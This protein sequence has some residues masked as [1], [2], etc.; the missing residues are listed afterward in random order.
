MF[1]SGP[2]RIVGP[3]MLTVCSAPLNSAIV[4]ICCKGEQLILWG[5]GRPLQTAGR[6]LQDCKSAAC[7]AGL[8]AWR[9]I[10]MAQDAWGHL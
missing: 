5:V 10:I 6:L 3:N 8:M 2:T 9:P 4:Q 7:L 1:V